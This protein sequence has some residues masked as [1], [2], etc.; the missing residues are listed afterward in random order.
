MLM[1]V[2]NFH[3][4]ILSDKAS[5]ERKIQRNKVSDLCQRNVR[6]FFLHILRYDLSVISFGC[7][8]LHCIHQSSIGIQ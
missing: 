8:L 2:L 1:K 7:G 5:M 6:E 4:K 3:G